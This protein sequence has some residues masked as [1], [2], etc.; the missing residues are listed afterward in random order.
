M[1]I[2]TLDIKKAYL[3]A[4]E[5]THSNAFIGT[6]PMIPASASYAGLKMTSTGNSTI[7]FNQG[8]TSYNAPD[9]KYSLN[10][11]S[12][13]TQWDFSAISLTDGQTVCFKGNNSSISYAY[14]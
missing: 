6:Y 2:G 10:N 7:S 14:N 12:T 8:A 5:L 1:K 4:L 3:G 9:L 11:G 13:W